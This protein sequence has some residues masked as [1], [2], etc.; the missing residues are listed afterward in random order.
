MLEVVPTMMPM[1][2][3]AQAALVKSKAS[4]AI[5]LVNSKKRRNEGRKESKRVSFLCAR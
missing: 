1:P 4:F 5:T 3:E 2:K